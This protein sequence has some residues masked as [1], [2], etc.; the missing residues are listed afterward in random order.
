MGLYF[1]ILFVICELIW[2]L[3]GSEWRM[4]QLLVQKCMFS[5]PREEYMPSLFHFC[6]QQSQN[7]GP[8]LS[9]IP[10]KHICR[11]EWFSI[12]FQLPCHSSKFPI[13]GFWESMIWK[14]AQV[15]FVQSSAFKEKDTQQSPRINSNTFHNIC[16][17]GLSVWTP[18]NK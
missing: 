5:A 7:L 8:L 1:V 15:L 14:M 11:P 18:R 3:Q 9:Y 13:T 12:I 10:N 17:L 2:N 6:K 4:G 16:A